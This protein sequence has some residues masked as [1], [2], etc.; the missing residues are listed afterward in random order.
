[1]VCASRR[2]RNYGA[3]KGSS[4]YSMTPGT[5]SGIFLAHAHRDRASSH[6]MRVP[7]TWPRSPGKR[8][9]AAQDDPPYCLH[10]YRSTEVTIY[11]LSY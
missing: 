4:P 6:R 2:R 11:F 5:M 7:R 3:Y 8:L 9:C 1:M 10:D